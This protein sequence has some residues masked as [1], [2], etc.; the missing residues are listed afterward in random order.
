MNAREHITRTLI[1]AVAAI[2]GCAVGFYAGKVGCRDEIASIQAIHEYSTSIE[3]AATYT[4]LLLDARRGDTTGVVQRLETLADD[5]LLRASR[6][7]LAHVTLFLMISDPPW[8]QLERDRQE[9]PR[10]PTTPERERQVTHMI[11]SLE[12]AQPQ[13]QD[14]SPLPSAPQAGSEGGR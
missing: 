7:K 8:T 14:T 12:S 11:E 2:I 9:H 3:G 6:V 13:R 5:S 10:Q 1:C 4:S